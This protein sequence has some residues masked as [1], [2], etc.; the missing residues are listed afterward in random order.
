MNPKCQDSIVQGGAPVAEIGGQDQGILQDP[1]DDF[2]EKFTASF[3]DLRIPELSDLRV[4]LLDGT[5][6]TIPESVI[7]KETTKRVRISQR[8]VACVGEATSVFLK[9]D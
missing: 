4:T 2:W 1:T 3:R 5:A 6:L 8:W 7:Q 9:S